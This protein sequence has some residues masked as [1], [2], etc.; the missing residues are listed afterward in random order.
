VELFDFAGA[1]G[2]GF[3]NATCV[4][5]LKRAAAGFPA[6]SRV[7]IKIGEPFPS[8]E[9]Q[10]ACDRTRAAV[11][12]AAT[13]GGVVRVVPTVDFG[14]LAGRTHPAWAAGVA[15]RMG[16]FLGQFP[17]GGAV[18]CLVMGAFTG[19]RVSDVISSSSSSSAT[20]DE[21]QLLQVLLF[22]KWVGSTDTNLFN[23]MVDDQ[24]RILS[25][26]ENP[27]SEPALRLKLGSGL[28]T[29][30]PMRRSLLQGAARALKDDPARAGAFLRRLQ[31][32]AG[33]LPPGLEAGAGRLAATHAREPFDE[34]TIALLEGQPTAPQMLALCRR[35]K[36]ETTYR[37]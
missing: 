1:A 33:A 20:V 29:A 9:F 5:R 31:T 24:G 36:H 17:P 12:L 22:R 35:R 13:G 26:D 19:A 11:G 7:F 34:E 2:L 27:A 25:V 23:L 15:R 28:V 32:L 4:V 14:A 21:W 16:R 10:V 30:Q 6:G 37:P 18:P 3:K 8:L